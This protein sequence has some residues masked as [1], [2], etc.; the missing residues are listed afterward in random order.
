MH[1]T[2]LWF[3]VLPMVCVG[4][5][6]PVTQKQDTPVAVMR[7][8]V[9]E[10]PTP[11]SLYVPSAYSNEKD[12]PLVVTLHGTY[13]WDGSRRQVREW[14]HLAE[15]KGFLVAAPDLRSVQGILPVPGGLW[16]K[17]LQRDEQAILRLVDHVSSQYRIDPKAVLLTGFS[18]GGYPMYYAGLR[19]PQRFNMLIARACN[20]KIELCEQIRL[21]ESTRKLP[22]AIFW[23]KDDLQEIR[24]QSWQAVRWL[25]E[26]GFENLEYDKISGGHLRRPDVAY[27][28]WKRYLPKRHRR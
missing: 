21:S 26:H 14:K 4:S 10:P 12:W 9:P 7:L 22:I 6:C 24:D 19:N 20:S 8:R 23:G 5:G 25:G 15:E 11:Y 27:A 17:D 2:L 28:Y 1:R 18:A 13:G 3:A 16:Q